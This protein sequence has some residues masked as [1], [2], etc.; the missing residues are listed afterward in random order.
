MEIDLT[1]QILLAK[2]KKTLNKPFRLPK[3][4][5]KKFGVYVK[6]EK[7]NIVIVKFG[8]PKM[9]IKRD[10][11]ARRKSFRARHNC[12]NPGPKTKA[13]YW[14]CKMW[15]KKKSV[16]DYLSKGEEIDFDNLVEQSEL[17][18]ILPSL[19]DAEIIESE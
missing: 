7:G 12:E 6:N 8:D 13:R 14:S 11:P 1:D 19:K 3:G 15:E 16:K 5:R 17:I 9:E 4:D 10:D 2:E 18:K